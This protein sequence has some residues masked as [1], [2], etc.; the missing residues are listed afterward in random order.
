RGRF[1][2]SS[3]PR[4][5]VPW[6]RSVR[7]ASD[8]SP[9]RL[10]GTTRSAEAPFLLESRRVRRY[11]ADGTGVGP[12]LQAFASSR[13]SPMLVQE[14][15]TDLEPREVLRLAREFFSTRFS[16]YAAFVEDESESHIAFRLEAGELVIGAGRQDGRTVVR[17]STSRLHH[18]L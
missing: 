9:P 7:S 13:G 16:P 11:R 6:W 4:I 5:C 17:G 2:C 14:V 10:M 8:R 12:E 3:R 1:R 18:E 15:R